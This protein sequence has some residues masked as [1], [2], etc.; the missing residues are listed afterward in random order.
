MK[1]KKLTLPLLVIGIAVGG[2]L[3][4]YPTQAASHNKSEL[5]TVTKSSSLADFCAKLPLA[6]Q[7]QFI[8]KIAP[9]A[10][11]AAQTNGLYPSVMIAQAILESNWGT[12]TASQAPN[13]NLFGIKG[14]YAG[15]GVS[16]ATS[17]WN[18]EHDFY[19]TNA[20]FRKYPSMAAS[21]QDYAHIL[22]QGIASDPNYYRG[23]WRQSTTSYRDATAWLQG[24]YATDPN[25]AAKLNRLIKNYQL[26]KY[27]GSDA[28]A[29][30][31]ASFNSLANADSFKVK[32]H[33]NQ[34]R[35]NLY[36][37]L[38]VALPGRHLNPN[39]T[40]S[41]NEVRYINGRKF[42]RLAV[43]EWLQATDVE[44]LS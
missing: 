8:N 43:Y 33:P 9:A 32:T 40:Y 28:A 3:L 42:Y 5:T 20:T 25:Y 22:R 6:T 10:Q 35:I 24:R 1:T 39:T 18:A 14:N 12:S 36:S 17:E 19:Q 7:E 11:K 4:S 34:G 26:N 2:L 31:A 15:T 23:T 16:L 38:G 27:D 37:P 30:A 29:N 44:V 41:C 13:Y 21:F